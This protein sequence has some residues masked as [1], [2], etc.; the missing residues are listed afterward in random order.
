MELTVNRTRTVSMNQTVTW[1][2]ISIVQNM[3]VMSMAWT[4]PS[5]FTVYHRPSSL[6]ITSASTTLLYQHTSATKTSVILYHKPINIVTTHATQDVLGRLNV[7]EDIVQRST[8]NRETTTET[9]LPMNFPSGWHSIGRLDAATSGLL[10]LTNDGGLVHHVTNHRAASLFNSDNDSDN[11]RECCGDGPIQKT[12]EVLV[13][14]YHSDDSI[15]FERFR[16][17]GIDLGNNQLTLPVQ[18]IHILDHPTSTTTRL[19]LS[20]IEGRNR[21]IRRMFHTCGSGV[22]KLTRTVIGSSKSSSVNCLTINMVPNEGDWY[23]VPDELIVSTLGWKPRSL[24]E[25]FSTIKN[26]PHHKFSKTTANNAPAPNRRQRPKSGR[27]S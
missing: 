16:E 18:D 20:I 1:I 25:S 14:G 7:Y 26:V 19:T 21:Q 13:M 6:S 5:V 2:L 12:Y 9:P 15:M 11:D 22:M 17:G 3:L 4:N 10:L 27:R 23:I 8:T 24:L